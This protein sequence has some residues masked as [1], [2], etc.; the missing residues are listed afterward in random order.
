MLI[1]AKSFYKLD[2]KIILHLYTLKL[3]L[4]RKFFL[5]KSEN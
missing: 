1:K 3:F 2:R 4:D 5:K